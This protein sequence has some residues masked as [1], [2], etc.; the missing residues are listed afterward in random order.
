MTVTDHNNLIYFRNDSKM[1]LCRLRGTRR[2]YTSTY[3]PLPVT[4]A[5]SDS[6]QRTRMT[7]SNAAPCAKRAIILC[8]IK[9]LRNLVKCYRRRC[10]C[11]SVLLRIKQLKIFDFNNY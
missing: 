8:E 6:L 3:I 1:P 4:F 7:I 2:M 5:Y 11:A 9:F 10:N